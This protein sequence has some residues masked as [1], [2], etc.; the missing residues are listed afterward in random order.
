M[1]QGEVMHRSKLGAMLVA[2]AAPAA[3]ASGAIAAVAGS[4]Y[5]TVAQ[6]ERLV[7]NS[8]FADLNAIT[9][10]NCVGLTTPKPRSN[11]LGQPTYH[12]FTCRLSGAYFDVTDLVVL[13]SDGGFKV[14]RL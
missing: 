11:A 10:V 14:H 12:R 8:Q 3:F 9:D 1:G 13:T 6:T 2:L 5:A 4:A 7:L